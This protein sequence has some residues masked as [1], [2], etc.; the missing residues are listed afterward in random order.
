MTPSTVW[1]TISRLLSAGLFA[2]VGVVAI[3][4]AALASN[5]NAVGLAFLG[6][7]T[8]GTVGQPTS[9]FTV[10]TVGPGGAQT[11]VATLVEITLGASGP[12]SFS[13][14]AIPVPAGTAGNASPGLPS[15]PDSVTFT[16]AAEGTVTLTASAP[17][18]ASASTE[19]TVGATLVGSDTAARDEFGSSVAVSGGT[20]V[21]GAQNARPAGRAYVFQEGAGGWHQTSKLVGS[22]T[23]AGDAFGWS[24]AVSGGTVVVGAPGHAINHAIGA[25]RAYVFKEGAGG[26]H[27]TAEL[28][29]SDTDPGD[30]FGWSVAVSGGTVVVGAYN[31]AIG[32]GRAYV[33]QEGAGGWHQTAELVGSDTAAQDEFGWSVAV[34][35]GTVVVGA[36]NHAHEA[37]RAYV[38][39]EGAGGWHQTAEL[40][41]SDTAARDGF[42]YSVAVSGGT[43][44]VGAPWHGNVAGRAY[45]FHEGAG[46]WHQTTELV[47]SD[48]AAGDH[49]G[50][51]DAVSGGTVVVGAPNHAIY[52]GGAYVF[53]EGAGGWHQTT[54]LVGSADEFGWSVAVSGGTVVVGAPY[55]AKDA[56]RAYLFRS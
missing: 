46:G 13:L 22:D 44:V 11:P 54:E 31:H 26:W 14:G 55:H 32:A 17:G 3:S 56:G 2:A 51:S 10:I 36:D 9:A 23:A 52:A 45:V 49:F 28:V 15:G 48:T 35:G 39:Q 16:P 27:Q 53:H 30:A 20:A 41:G 21:V 19:L 18:L 4:E 50:V 33:F 25:G 29:S 1:R 5:G 12:G 47:G 24:V 34:S 43:A 7:P 37:G 6:A 8:I 40:V 38:F 42:G